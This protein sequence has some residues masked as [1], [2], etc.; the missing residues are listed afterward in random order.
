MATPNIFRDFAII[1]GFVQLPPNY[2]ADKNQFLVS[3]MLTAIPGSYVVTLDRGVSQSGTPSL[4]TKRH[5]QFQLFL[6]VPGVTNPN[7]MALT[8]P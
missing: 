5:S 6:R 1:N 2:E 3:E 4:Y 7:V 8:T